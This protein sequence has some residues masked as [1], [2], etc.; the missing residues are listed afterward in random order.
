MKDPV[1]EGLCSL[2]NSQV[3]DR[4]AVSQNPRDHCSIP[5]MR[6]RQETEA[7]KIETFVTQLNSLAGYEFVFVT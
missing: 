2:V 7:L 3:W 4:T 5:Y 1:L 6:I